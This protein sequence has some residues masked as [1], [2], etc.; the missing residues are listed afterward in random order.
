MRRALID[1]DNPSWR[2]ALGVVA[3][4]VLIPVAVV[5]KLVTMP[6]ER[7]HKRT[8]DEVAR[9]LRGFL[10]DTGGDWDWD[11]FTSIP[12]ADPGLESIRERAARVEL[13]LTEEGRTTLLALL[14][15]AEA[16]DG[17]RTEIP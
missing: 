8:A 2:N 1:P 5:V 6:F 15:E 17:P 12:L 9:Y 16:T 13:P 11:D 3:A 14:A 4:A 7:P 10:E